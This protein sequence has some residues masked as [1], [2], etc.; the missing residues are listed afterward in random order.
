M[1][2][3]KPHLHYSW[4]ITDDTDADTLDAPDDHVVIERSVVL[5]AALVLLLTKHFALLR[6]FALL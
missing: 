5:A 3:K 1:I 6:Q 2:I 4:H